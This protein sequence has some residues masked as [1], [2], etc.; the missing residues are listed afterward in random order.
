VETR[1]QVAPLITPY[2]GSLV[3]LMVLAEARD[4]MKAYASQLPSL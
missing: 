2:G 4:A 1:A 3:D